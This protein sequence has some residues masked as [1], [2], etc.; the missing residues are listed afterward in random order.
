MLRILLGL[1][2][3]CLFAGAASEP[4]SGLA[5]IDISACPITYFGK[6]Y[7]SLTVDFNGSSNLVAC[8]DD[9][10]GAS[11][12][13]CVKMPVIP[14]ETF[15][16]DIITDVSSVSSGISTDFTH[17]SSSAV[18]AVKLSFTL[19]RLSDFY[20][21]NYDKQAAAHVQVDVNPLATGGTFDF[22]V[23]SSS[24][25][26]ASATSKGVFTKNVDLTGCR[27]GGKAYKN[28]EL[29][30]DP[31]TCTTKKCSSGALVHASICSTDQICLG[32]NVC[33]TESFCSVIGPAVIDFSVNT[34]TIPDLCRYTLLKGSE[35]TVTGVF[36]TRRLTDTP[37]LTEVIIKTTD[38]ITLKQGGVVDVNPSGVETFSNPPVIHYGVTLTKD[39]TGVTAVFT[40]TSSIITKLFFDGTLLS[41]THTVPSTAT[42]YSEGVCTLASG[43]SSNKDTALS[44][45]G[46]NIVIQDPQGNVIDCAA[47]KQRCTDKL[48]K[49]SCAKS[50]TAFITA[51]ADI[52][53]CTYPDVDDLYCYFLDA[54]ARSCKLDNWKTAAGCSAS[55]CLSQPCG[56]NEF[57]VVG[58]SGDRACYCQAAFAAPFRAN[59]SYGDVATCSADSASLKLYTCFLEEKGINYA[60]LHLKNPDCKG[61]VD[62]GQKTVG[63]SFNGTNTCQ[64]TIEDKTTTIV[65]SNNIQN[66]QSSTVAFEGPVSIG[67]SCTYTQPAPGHASFKIADGPVTL[68]YATK[69]FT[70]SLGISL[71]TDAAFTQTVSA[72]TKLA[73]DQKVWVKLEAKDV[74][75][76]SLA[77]VINDCWT[78]PTNDP[79]G[80]NQYNL[81]T[82]KCAVPTDGS[83]EVVSSGAGLTSFFTFKTF[84]YVGST[85]VTDIF[86]HCKVSLCI[87]ANGCAPTCPPPAPVG[88]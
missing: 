33:A 66:T 56:S 75:G 30:S 51:C 46:C 68:T 24:F 6:E 50:R 12:V 2:A 41:I 82:S 32:N 85:A 9:S 59:S 21:I 38:S 18:C 61:K 3:L 19:R 15:S 27:D 52:L 77:L 7:K 86:L 22:L 54:Y 37:F 4:H 88:K 63:F 10:T 29:S 13:D 81:I 23:Q 31:A 34:G 64:G 44:L 55:V 74:G 1:S 5:T 11:P 20:F 25:D 28:N 8:F 16:S 49:V 35:L 67:F 47:A 70:F 14:T 76:N 72:S 43:V 48:N 69:D 26:S 53:Y 78:T 60:G 36:G 45:P 83:V 71:F 84:E 87:L 65:Y 39:S 73:L 79:N 42:S 57:C 40:D 62:S 80:A 58:P 17:I